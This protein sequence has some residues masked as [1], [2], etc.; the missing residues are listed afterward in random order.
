MKYFRKNHI[1]YFFEIFLRKNLF[2]FI[3]YFKKINIFQKLE[4]MTSRQRK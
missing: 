1:K 2:F 4:N 3:N